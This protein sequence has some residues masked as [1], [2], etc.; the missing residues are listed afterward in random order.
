MYGQLW[1]SND[2]N[3][4]RLTSE[5]NKIFTYNQAETNYRN[6]SDKYYNFHEE[7]AKSLA[8]SAAFK[9]SANILGIASSSM[10]V[11]A[12]VNKAESGA[13]EKTT[14]DV[15]SLTD[16]KKYLDQK[17]IETEWKGEKIIPKSFQVYRLT[18]ITDNLQV[19]LMA[20]ELTA[21]KT[22]NAMIRTLSTLN[23]P[24][25]F[26]GVTR[27]SVIQSSTCMIGEIRLYAADTHPP[28][29][30]LFCNG[31]AISRIEYQ[32]LFS[33]I[34]ASFGAG[35]GKT[36][37]NVPD[38][39][40]R[41]PLGLNPITS[42]EDR[43]K[44]GGNKEHTLT[45]DQMPTHNHSADALYTANAG[46]HKHAVYDPGHNHGGFTG[47]TNAA[48]KHD[49]KADGNHGRGFA[50]HA[51][52]KHSIP[53]GHTGITLSYDGSHAHPIDGSTDPVGGEKSFS[54]MPPYQTIAYIIFTGANCA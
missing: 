21:E 31:T 20:R 49:Y 44:K 33:I 22:S 9:G 46:S 54:I 37:F 29:P 13:T 27:T 43:W 14:H 17:S 1:S 18:D 23:L 7:Y 26:G 47:E 12:L 51:N 39:R 38:F 4:D 2:L 8:V 30:W 50:E 16:I 24:P 48:R 3:P 11:S 36:T 52:H 19:A 45:I 15:I 34:G 41:F 53:W 6:T 35:D 32:R 10:D 25:T 28:F 40:D 5:L 42:Q